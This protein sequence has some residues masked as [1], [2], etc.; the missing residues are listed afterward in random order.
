MVRRSKTEVAVDIL[1]VAIKGATITHITYE[2]KLNFTIT[3]KYLKILKE[4]ELVKQENNLFITTNKGKT[5]QEMAKE[6][7]L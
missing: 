6:L 2:A 1:K 7:K 4:K 5:F 3:Q